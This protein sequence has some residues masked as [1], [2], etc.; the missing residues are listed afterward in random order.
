MIFKVQDVD[1]STGGPL[2]AIM[3]H[4]DALEGDFHYEDRIRVTHKKKSTI[5]ILDISESDKQVPSGRIGLMEEVLRILEVRHGSIVK[6][7][8]EKTPQSVHYIREKL[9]GKELG[10]EK[11]EEIIKDIVNNSLT[12]VEMTYFVAGCYHKGLS[13]QEIVNLTKSIV[14]NGDT[15]KPKSKIVVDKH[16]VGGVPGNRTTMVVVP[17]VAAAGLTIPKTSSRSITSPAGTADSMEVLAEVSLPIEKLKRI[18]GKVHACMIW[19]GAFSLA[20]ADD[21]LIRLRHPLSLDPIGM[22]LASVLAKKK[23]VN[24][25]HVLVDI[26]LGKGAKIQTRLEALK[27]KHLFEGI[28]KELGMKVKAIITDG[29]QPIGNGIGPALEARDVLW[30]LQNNVRAPQDLIKKSLLAAGEIFEMVGKSEKGEGRKLAA[31]L[32]Y[33][34][35]GYNKMVQI[36]KAQGPKVT[37]PSK[38]ILGKHRLHIRATKSGTIRHIDNKTISRIAWSAGAPVDKTAGLYLY[39]HK[40]NRV[41]TGEALYT[42]YS[43]SREK[44]RFA[45]SLA[46]KN[47]GFVI[48]FP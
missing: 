13:R 3:N 30:A 29:S 2:I 37:D 42:I 48:R 17:L 27:F 36:I 39:K 25:T 21:K 40:G 9:D 38:I 20:A 31:Q 46:N 1:I 33:S 18:I 43:D 44:L 19:G 23:A 12:P 28:G 4:K 22:V 6:V 14:H 10:K 26:P 16:C 41:K 34:G 8:S 5:A 35:E 24:A 15:F 45:A 32:L 7:E 47:S 11:I